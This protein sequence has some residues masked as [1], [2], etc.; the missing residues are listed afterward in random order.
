MNDGTV[1]DNSVAQAI[2]AAG[3][4][5]AEAEANAVMAVAGQ[6]DQSFV[7]CVS[8]IE[9]TTGKII[10]FGSGTSG[11][12]ARRFAH[13]MSVSGTPAVF[14]HPMDALHGT[15]GAIETDDLVFTFSKGGES[16]EINNLCRKLKEKDITIVAVTESP[17]STMA[18]LANVVVKLHT[19]E[20][21]DPGEVLAMASTL[22]AGV[23]GDALARVL[24][25]KEHRTWAET[26]WLHPAGAVGMMES[27]PENPEPL[28]ET[29]A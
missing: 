28:Q 20:G 13:L 11:S 15:M 9:N 8:L 22:V 29:E 12:V 14:I 19:A 25:R 7:D 10:A 21:G 23:W 3:R 24:M 6:L 4:E 16:T 26:L 27:V 1:S 18:R 5:A 2:L 17:E